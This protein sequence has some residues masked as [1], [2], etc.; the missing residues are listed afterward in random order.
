MTIGGYLSVDWGS[1]LRGSALYAVSTQIMGHERPGPDL[2][3]IQISV[4]RFR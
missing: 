3:Q 2:L 1:V 4:L